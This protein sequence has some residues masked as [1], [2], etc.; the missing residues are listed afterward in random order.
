ME[1]R[2]GK[3]RRNPL[4]RKDGKSPEILKHGAITITAE[5]SCLR[6]WV[7]ESEKKRGV[8]NLTPPR[9]KLFCGSEL[10]CYLLDFYYR[11][12]WSI[13]ILRSNKVTKSTIFM[14]KFVCHAFTLPRCANKAWQILKVTDRREIAS[15]R[16]RQSLVKSL[17]CQK[18]LF[19]SKYIIVGME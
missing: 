5:A 3:I 13:L 9:V 10:I 16:K 12:S 7:W 15:N 6:R 2:K 19:P 8:V 17:H 4:R 14:S 1:T 11:F 18:H